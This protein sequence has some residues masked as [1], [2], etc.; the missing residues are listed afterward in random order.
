MTSLELLQSFVSIDLPSRGVLIGVAAALVLAI[1]TI[2][3][4]LH[5]KVRR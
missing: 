2:G 1:P 4:I 3:V 5:P